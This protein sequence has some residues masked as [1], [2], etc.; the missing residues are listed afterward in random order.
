MNISDILISF[1]VPIYKVEKYLRKCIDSIC[2]QTFTNIEII[3]VDD[4]S[5]DSCPEICDEYS[6][7]DDRIKVIHKKN[8]GL[9]SARK[10][11]LAI[12][13]GTY[14]A[15]VDG[16]DWLD[17]DALQQ[18]V[19]LGINTDIICFSAWEE[20]EDGC[21]GIKKHTI[22]EGLY[23]NPNDLNKLYGQM[24][25][26]GSFFEI[27]ILPYQW[28]KLIKRELLTQ[29][30]K[31]VPEY[32]SYAEDAACIYPCLL[33]A[34]SIYITNLPLYHYRIS[35]NSMVKKE[36]E[37]EKLHHLFVV[38]SKAFCSHNLTATLNTQLKYYMW[39]S[40][41]LKGYSYIQASIPLFPFEK[42]KAG[43]RVAVYGAGLFGAVI[44]KYCRES[45]YLSVA[46]WFDK[47]YDI[48][49]KQGMDV[50][51][52]DEALNS[53]FDIMVIAILNV[54]LSKFIKKNYISLGMNEN[55]IDLINVAMLDQTVFPDLRRS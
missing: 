55:K 27:G 9:V 47:R 24:L 38:L 18:L 26:N 28:G 7:K 37:P 44:E 41:L 8:G 2:H 48:Y 34:K 32:I 12:A 33:K 16:D 46:G 40:L 35:P 39:Q 31:E 52:N 14:I 21:H 1:V 50:K 49:I 15:C 53:D 20:Y 11:G 22:S 6:L 51:S 10:A 29:C 5:P 45:K 4:G 17:T 25:M 54:N 3:L 43:M 23:E 30:Q 42:V 19:N 36:V 13:S